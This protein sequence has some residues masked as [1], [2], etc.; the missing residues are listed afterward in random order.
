MFHSVKILVAAVFG[1]EMIY[2]IFYRFEK[3]KNIQVGFLANLRAGSD[4]LRGTSCH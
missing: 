1:L 4:V 2:G 3:V